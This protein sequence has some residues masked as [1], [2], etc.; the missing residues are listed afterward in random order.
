MTPNQLVDRIRRGDVDDAITDFLAATP[1]ATLEMLAVNAM[2]WQMFD[3]AEPIL[4]RLLRDDPEN[5]GG[6]LTL[7][8][9]LYSEKRFADALPHFEFTAR[10]MPDDAWFQSGRLWGYSVLGQLDALRDAIVEIKRKIPTDRHVNW[11]HAR[12]VKNMPDTTIRELAARIADLRA[13]S[14]EERRAQVETTKVVTWTPR[15]RK[16]PLADGIDLFGWSSGLS[17]TRAWFV[18]DDAHDIPAT[19]RIQGDAI[20]WSATFIPSGGQRH[21]LRL[22]LETD[23]RRFDGGEVTYA[24]PQPRLPYAATGA[25]TENGATGLIMTGCVAAT[26]GAAQY[27]FEYGRSSDGLVGETPW[28]PVPGKRNARFVASPEWATSRSWYYGAD[29]TWID[30]LAPNLTVHWPFAQD[31]N[32]ISGIG[33][34]ELLFACWHN[35]CQHD[36]NQRVREWECSDLR[37]AVVS[38][39]LHARDLD[40][41]NYL[42][43]LGIGNVSTY[44][45]LSG[46]AVDLSSLGDQAVE[47][48]FTLPSDPAQWTFAGNNQIEQTAYERYEYGPLDQALARNQGNLVLIAPFGTP[49]ETTTGAVSIDEF[50]VSYRD[51]N[52]LH[53]DNGAVL[54]DAPSLSACD[55]ANLTNGI[56]GDPDAGWFRWG[57]TDEPARFVWEFATP[58]A[59]TTL[60]IHQD[61]VLPTTKCRVS[62]GDN[63]GSEDAWE[64]DLPV[65]E[66]PYDQPALKI[67]AFE[68]SGTYTWV[69][70]ELLEGKYPE[71]Q[72]MQSFEIFARN[73]APPPSDLPVTVSADIQGMQPGSSI[74]YRVV[75]RTDTE[76]AAGEVQRF[77]LPAENGPPLLHHVAL[78]EASGTKAIFQVRANAMGAAAELCW[79]LDDD[80]GHSLPL[81][82]ERTPVHRYIVLPNVPE[83]AHRLTVRAR[84]AAGDSPEIV[85][86]WNMPSQNQD[87]P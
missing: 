21:R 81:G 65:P 67:A 15:P 23:G 5:L 46:Q 78:F 2:N 10:H 19:G 83:G 6:H 60:V 20:L 86:E 27:R 49:S 1:E 13:R 53:P 54:I 8:R 72:G 33:F 52:I 44:W 16:A 18:I 56:Y 28:Q 30:G 45:M 37:D 84:S 43:C 11:Q 55:P 32:H 66:A 64:F 79:R 40:P 73:F 47:L 71:G 34:M 74:H 9:G 76:T 61:P 25:A 42:H 26:D 70:L 41:K 14:V 75:T 51:N 31:P 87:S 68:G 63:A 4:H 48:T 69:A 17:E 50:T 3:V 80:A 57:N 62:L 85:H 77:D 39:R 82:W 12:Q 22:Y 29:M 24:P 59:I 7:A 36:G 58:Q 38:V 35:S